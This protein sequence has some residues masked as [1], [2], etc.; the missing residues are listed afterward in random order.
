MQAKTEIKKADSQRRHLER[1]LDQHHA[2]AGD[3]PHGVAGTEA[4]MS[5]DA[6]FTPYTIY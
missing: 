2:I 1:T 3:L 6:G 5:V 4:G